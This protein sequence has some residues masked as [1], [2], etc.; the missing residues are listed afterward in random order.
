MQRN[1]LL[2]LTLVMVGSLY[3]KGQA[4][5]SSPFSISG[6]GELKSRSFPQHQAMGGTSVSQVNKGVFTPANPASYANIDFTVFGVGARASIGELRSTDEKVNTSS[7]NF[8]HFAMAFP[9]GTKRKMGVSF[10]TNQYSDVGYSITNNVNID[11]PSYY[12]LFGGTGGISRVYAGYGVELFKNFK[13]GANVNY[14]FGNIQKVKA[15]VYPNTNNVLSYNDERF[16]AYRGVDYTL[17][18]QYSVQQNRQSEGV[19]KNAWLHTFGAAFQSDSRL[20]GVG[21]RYSETFYGTAFENGQS[22]TVD[23]LRFEDNKRDTMSKPVGFTLGYTL[24]QGDKWSVA[25]EMEQNQWSDVTDSKTG[26][27]FFN[28]VRYSAGIS[29]VPSPNYNEKGD[30]FKKVRYSAGVRYENLYFNFEDMQ[31]SEL[32]I[33][34]GLGLPVV[35]SFRLEGEKVAVVS[36]VNLTAEY[37]QRGTTNNGLLQENFFNIGIGLN[38][39]D[40][41]FTKRKY[42]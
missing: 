34:I 23:T 9:I 29:V 13:L 36:M 3:T 15:T 39:N 32:G 8:N 22:F 26:R 40:K 37:V 2:L 20:N 1:K 6:L 41:W 31:I 18:V 30:F 14:N 16:L 25:L 11:T 17:G 21:Y 12:N 38:L 4:G 42:Q 24:S 5:T 35:R 33:S 7:G 10:G 28:N 27:T 19:A